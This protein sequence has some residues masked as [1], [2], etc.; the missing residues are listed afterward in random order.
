MRGETKFVL[1]KV[2]RALLA[3]VLLGVAVVIFWYLASHYRGKSPKPAAAKEILPQKVERQEQ[4]RYSEFKGE[5]GR[6]QVLAEKHY[7]S[8]DNMFHLEGNVEIRDFGR[9]GGQEILIR[10][11]KVTY[12][13]EWLHFLLSGRVEAKFEDMRLQSDYLEYD[14]EGKVFWTEKGG[15][16]FSRR[17]SGTAKKIEYFLDREEAVLRDEVKLEMISGEEGKPPFAVKGNKFFFNRREKIGRMEGS[18]VF[19][20]SQNHG[21]SEFL[22]FVVSEDEQY[23]RA[24]T[25]KGTVRG[26]FL[27]E[28]TGPLPT[29]GRDSPLLHS[30]KREIEADE[31]EIK[32]FLN[33]HK[34]HAVDAKGGCLL[35]LYSPGGGLTEISSREMAFVFDRWGR[36]REFKVTGEGEVVEKGPDSLVERR[37][38]GEEIFLRGNTDVLEVKGKDRIL[39]RMA[40]EENEI[41]AQALT[42]FLG[43][44]DLDA[45]GEVKVVLRL[46]REEGHSSGLFSRDKPVFIS[47]GEMRYSSEEKRFFFKEGVKIWQE[48]EMIL[49]READFYRETGE[50]IC[51]EGVHSV[52]PYKPKREGAEEEQ[53]EI[54][55]GKMRFQP[56][57]NIISYE[58]N[59][60]LKA[61][62]LK[63][64]SKTLSVHLKQEKGEAREAVAGGNV[65][66]V[67]DFREGR[68]EEARYRIEEEMMTLTGNPVL[69]DKQQGIVRGDKLTFH[70][71]DDRI[72]VENKEKERSVTIIKS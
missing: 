32:A 69:V 41:Q 36:L 25:L 67:Q 61:R 10:A 34:I 4:I 66:L 48:K 2:V 44:N 24:L 12:D 16:F 17:I 7:A 45:Y 3:F 63:L 62:N 23:L 56:K 37:I 72:L 52:F 19:A 60:I 30:S 33:M 50:M 31:V 39:S 9:K 29:A 6:I 13:R 43:T 42:L 59:C 22:E 1:A 46:P 28:E 51:D 71:A 20:F 55:S 47:A 40:S 15:A 38:S 5:R 18:V 65:V 70:L 49:A 14:K 57:D 58:K 26:V 27:G 64:T 21:T 35:K 8:Q 53:V 68:G 11:D 54:E